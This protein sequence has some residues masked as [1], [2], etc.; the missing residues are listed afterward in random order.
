MHEWH[1]AHWTKRCEYW[2]CRRAVFSP[3]RTRVASGLEDRT[4]RLWSVADMAE[5][6]FY[7]SGTYYPH[8]TFSDDSTKIVV[9]SASLSILSQTLFPR[10]TARS[11]RFH[12]SVPISELGVTIT[13]SFCLLR[14]FCGFLPN[15]ALEHGQIKATW[16]LSVVAL[17][18]SRLLN[19]LYRAL[20]HHDSHFPSRRCC[21]E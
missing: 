13:R 14:G 17:V 16:L 2:T 5:L 20:R 21:W 1:W 19:T 8:I 9:N 4:V 11:P 10:T 18:E 12:L 6:L 15:I 7:K 3:E